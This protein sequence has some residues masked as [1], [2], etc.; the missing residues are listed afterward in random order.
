[1]NNYIIKFE[2]KKKIDNTSP[3]LDTT[4][5]HKHA[6]I[7]K[8]HNHKEILLDWLISIDARTFVQIRTH[9]IYMVLWSYPFTH[10]T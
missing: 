5:I 2:F 3:K 7:D 8:S 10:V 9:P 4:Q 6:N 1:M